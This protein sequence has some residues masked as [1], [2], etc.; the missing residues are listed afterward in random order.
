MAGGHDQFPQ[1]EVTDR[2]ALRDWLSTHHATAG[3]HWLVTGKKAAGDRYIPYS[4]IV[5]ELL[6]FGWIDSLPRAL[7]D[8]RT[9][10][11]IGPRKP[12]SVWSA[13]N[14]D[15]VA[16]LQAA[17]QIMPAGDRVIA[18]ACADGSWDRLTASDSGEA[19]DDLVAALS[20]AGAMSSWLGFTRATRKRALE[21]LFAAKRLETRARRLERIVAA[22]EAGIDPTLWRPKD[23]RVG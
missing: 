17:G 20:R 6:C 22:S 2:A 5:E 10:V 3:P 1:V 8:L 9:M 15:R 23:Q 19:P 16:R 18:A 11:F 4:A 13:A 7:D 14:R 12:R 21:F